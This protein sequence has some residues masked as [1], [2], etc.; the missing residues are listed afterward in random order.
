M[1]D[2]VV[3]GGS[4]SSNTSPL[5][6]WATSV[7]GVLELATSF[8]GD[9]AWVLLL[10]PKEAVSSDLQREIEQITAADAA[11]DRYEVNVHASFA[12]GILRRCGVS[13][14]GGVRLF[15]RACGRTTG[16]LGKRLTAPL[17][18]E[19]SVEGW[20]ARANEAT[21][22]NPAASLELIP[23]LDGRNPRCSIAA[24]MSSFIVKRG[25]LDGCAGFRFSQFLAATHF[26]GRLKRR[27][28]TIE[29]VK[30]EAKPSSEAT[31]RDIA[32]T[33]VVP[34]LNEERNL[35]A[36][37]ARLHRFSHLV[38]V[39][40][41]SS[42]RTCEIAREYGA[43]VIDFKWDGRFPKKRNWT[44]RNHDFKTEFVLF[45]DADEYVS[46]A[47]CE[48]V[49]TKV[50]ATSHDG[51]W[52]SFHNFFLGR[53]LRHGT[54]FTKLA[55]LRVGAGEYERIEEERW[56]HLDMEVHE[57]PIL[58]GTTGSI[59]AP[60]EHDDYKG[61]DAYVK[62]HN[63]YSTWEAQRYRTLM[64][65]GGELAAGFTKRQRTKYRAVRRW[66]MASAYFLVTYI[67][68]LGFLDGRAGL[69]FAVMK[70]I[71]FSQIRLKIIEAD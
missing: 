20:I 35:P 19:E 62:R 16:R 6:G 42:D 30:R 52:L 53:F 12:D 57:H 13:S 5:S 40:S 37:L 63:E 47:F 25:F 41:G 8:P 45:L 65:A 28:A 7:H 10:D 4:E 9:A 44:L 68:Q 64:A 36:C 56:S 14:L 33:V 18:R 49:K 22:A 29:K 38:V 50:T 54:A 15:R 34:V 2:V 32:V 27:E 1:L 26:L 70:W 58:S 69:S 24:F 17:V 48:E 21:S 39:D 43:T 11:A 59:D 71:Y 51:F 61:L 23:G 31:D 55:L 46:E 3:V 60:I 67:V 66:W